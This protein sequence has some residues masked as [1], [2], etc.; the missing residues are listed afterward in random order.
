MTVFE[1]LVALTIGLVTIIGALEATRSAAMRTLLAQ[2]DVAAAAEAEQLMARV[3]PELPLA[4]GHT[5]GTALSGHR[6][7]V[8]VEPVVSTDDRRKA[9]EVSVSVT[10]GR[11][12][13]SVSREISTIKLG[14]Q[15]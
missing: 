10:V 8:T 15:R 9:F 7:S 6:W 2:L 4:P 14:M 12:V 5:Q 11:A 3:G 1:A 13:V